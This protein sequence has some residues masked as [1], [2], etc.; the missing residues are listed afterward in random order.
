MEFFGSYLSVKCRILAGHH[1]FGRKS[2]EVIP[3]KPKMCLKSPRV[4]VLLFLYA[5][6]HS[7]TV[8]HYRHSRHQD[9]YPPLVC[10]YSL[11]IQ[12]LYTHLAPW[13]CPHSP[14]IFSPERKRTNFPPT[15][16]VWLLVSTVLLYSPQ[17]MSSCLSTGTYMTAAFEN[18]IP[19]HLQSLISGEITF[20]KSYTVEQQICTNLNL[21]RD[22][23][24]LRTWTDHKVYR[25]TH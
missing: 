1:E 12:W 14:M 4:T 3:E 18:S 16:R 23:N 15:A 24:R 25:P 20:Q 6:T 7:L 5:H 10:V 11:H 8:L 2:Q 13:L 17:Q 22:M 19:F 9:H 21:H